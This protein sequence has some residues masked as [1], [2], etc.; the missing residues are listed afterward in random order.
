MKPV[1]LL[2][3]VV[4]LCLALCACGSTAP[5]EDGVHTSHTVKPETGSLQSE[6]IIEFDCILSTVA[7]ADESSLAGYTY[8]LRVKP[9]DGAMVGSYERTDRYGEC[10]KYVFAADDAFLSELHAMIVR[11]DLYEELNGIYE[12]TS[13]LPDMYGMDL[14]VLWEGGESLAAYDNSENWMSLAVMEELDALF[15]AQ[16]P[17]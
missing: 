11:N 10:E 13:G 4:V 17:Q 15:L 9:E 2:M 1:Y 16:K 8:K 14:T 5:E 6:R 7:M 12:H 3:L